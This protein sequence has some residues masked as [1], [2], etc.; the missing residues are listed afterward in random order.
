MGLYP[1]STMG[2]GI[3]SEYSLNLVPNPPQNKTTFI[4]LPFLTITFNPACGVIVSGN[5]T[6]LA[7][8]TDYVG[9]VGVQFKLDGANWGTELMT[10]PYSISWCTTTAANGCHTLTAVAQDAAGNQGTASSVVSVNKP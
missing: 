6:V 4:F 3:D 5:V 8:A 1:I 10:A 7:N 2:L 9:V